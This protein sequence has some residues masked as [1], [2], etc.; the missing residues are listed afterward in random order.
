MPE[1]V[2]NAK[3]HILLSEEE[4][5]TR[6][7][8]LAVEISRD[9]E[10]L[11]PLFVC[12]LKGSMPFFVDLSRKVSIPH[13]HDYLAVQSYEGTRSTGV[14][15]FVADLSSSIEGQ[16][17]ILVEDIVDTGL[18]MSYLLES[19]GARGPASLKV[20]TLLDKPSRREKPVEITY[21]GFEIPD[22]FVIGYGLDYEQYFRS[23]PYVAVLE[24]VP[25]L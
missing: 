11:D 24:Q 21:R 23:L 10:G 17:V 2:K 18:T 1:S 22:Q 14:V 5:Q 13:R 4:L 6:I 16:H 7:A 25:E 9:Y 8:E 3:M 12:I 19:L 20:A 15:K